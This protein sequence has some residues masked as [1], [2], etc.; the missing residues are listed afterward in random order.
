MEE[1]ASK[2]CLVLPAQALADQELPDEHLAG[3]VGGA[4]PGPMPAVIDPIPLPMPAAMPEPMPSPT[5]T[6]SSLYFRV[7]RY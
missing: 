1:T 3:V 4:I 6:L 2:L 7:R 5:M